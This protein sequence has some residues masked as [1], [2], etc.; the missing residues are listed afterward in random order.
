MATAAVPDRLLTPRRASYVMI[1]LAL[2]VVLLAA[3][4]VR[5]SRRLGLQESIR[6]SDA[7]NAEARRQ[8]GCLIFATFEDVAVE[9]PLKNLNDILAGTTLT[10]AE[11][12]DRMRARDRY[13]AARQKLSP[14]IQACSR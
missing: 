6:R 4:N 1:A 7:T 13:E 11:R 3:W 12:V 9:I 2:A 10:A 14:T 8:Q 5:L